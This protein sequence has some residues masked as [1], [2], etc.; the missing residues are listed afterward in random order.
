MRVKKRTK[1][2]RLR[3]ARTAG[4]GFRQSH[5]GHGA[6]GGFGMSGTGKKGDQKKQKAL[7]IA[8][9]AGFKNY[10]GKKGMTSLSTEKTKE[11][12]INLRDIQANFSGAKIDLKD[13]KILG[14]GDGFKAEITARA[15]SKSAIAKMEK[16]GGKIVLPVVKEKVK[17]D[18]NTSSKE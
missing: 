13:H 17:E 16:A 6:K 12:K 18:K 4:W 14:K 15:A 8:K 5:K 11:K 10:F 3:G 1:T 9:K 7:M 2:S